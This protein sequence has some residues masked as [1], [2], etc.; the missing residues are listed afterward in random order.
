VHTI[1]DLRRQ[2]EAAEGE[3]HLDGKD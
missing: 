3:E 1:E 2:D